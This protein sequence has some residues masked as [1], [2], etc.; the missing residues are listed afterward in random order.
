MAPEM[1]IKYLSLAEVAAIIIARED[2]CLDGASNVRS[3]SDN[4]SETTASNDA[5]TVRPNH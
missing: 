5:A 1:M 2:G 3:L 4:M